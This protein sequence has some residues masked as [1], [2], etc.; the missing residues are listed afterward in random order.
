MPGKGSAETSRKRDGSAVPDV[1]DSE[2]RLEAEPSLFRFQTPTPYH[3]ALAI[4]EERLTRDDYVIRNGFRYVRPYFHAYHAYCK[5]RWIGRK[6]AE[7]LAAEFSYLPLSYWKEA[8]RSGRLLLNGTQIPPGYVL[9]GRGVERLTH[10]VHRH[11]LPVSYVDRLEVL[12][13]DAELLVVN[14]PASIPVHP[15]GHYHRNSLQML[16]QVQMLSRCDR[17]PLDMRDRETVSGGLVE[18]TKACSLPSAVEAS[19][20]GRSVAKQINA[21]GPLYVIHRLDK[22]T[23]GV[24]LL[25]KTKDVARKHCEQLQRQSSGCERATRVHANEVS[26]KKLYLAQVDGLWTFESG[27]DEVTVQTHEPEA[28]AHLS[29]SAL[30]RTVDAL[31]TSYERER[32]GCADDPV[33]HVALNSSKASSLGTQTCFSEEAGDKRNGTSCRHPNERSNRGTSRVRETAP[34]LTETLSSRLD[35][36]VDVGLFSPSDGASRCARECTLPQSSSLASDTGICVP[37]ASD[38]GRAQPHS[39][40]FGTSSPLSGTVMNAATELGQAA[41]RLE[42][43]TLSGATLATDKHLNQRANLCRGSQPCPSRSSTCCD[44]M[45]AECTTLFSEFEHFNENREASSA[46]LAVGPAPTGRFLPFQQHPWICCRL[47]LT[48]DRSTNCTRVDQVRGKEA[49]TWL[50]PLACDTQDRR[51]LMACIPVTGRT[52]QIR[53]HLA[54]LGHPVCNDTLY[55]RRVDERARGLHSTGII[56]AAASSSPT[57]SA[58]PSL[59]PTERAKP[60][61]LQLVPVCSASEDP[62][63]TIEYDRIPSSHQSDRSSD[64]HHRSRVTNTTNTRCDS[65]SVG[66]LAQN[67]GSDERA[68]S[69]ISVVSETFYSTKMQVLDSLAEREPNERGTSVSKQRRVFRIAA[70]S[71]GAT[72][73]CAADDDASAL[74]CTI[75]PSLAAI[76]GAVPETID[77]HALCYG[78]FVAPLPDWAEPY[79]KALFLAGSLS[80]DKRSIA[81]AEDK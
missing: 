17:A 44:R 64:D 62:V 48:Y 53:V 23:S 34:T 57:L 2:R 41:S 79:Q 22:E 73:Y 56:P 80:G 78:D 61:R 68:S 58:S 42:S 7:A 21:A 47:R 12:Y 37:V 31:F 8:Q 46:E 65:T 27:A 32:Y 39:D 38:K 50:K 43:E 75:C 28:S 67:S 15:G 60:D 71:S 72:P 29:A 6:P 54:S 77:L 20:R 5:E 9:T 69:S 74:G 35:D 52:H 4:E 45:R 14:K 16:L 55:G 25:A 19:E 76:P 24:V 1:T 63:V 3:E 11:E 51:T 81:Q 49:E 40:R 33:G 30:K 70:Q 10:L 66:H 26:L 13:E 59:D 36:Q 18:R